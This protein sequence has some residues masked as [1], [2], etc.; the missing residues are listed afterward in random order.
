MQALAAAALVVPCLKNGEH[1]FEDSD[2]WKNTMEDHST[3]DTDRQDL[4][5]EARNKELAQATVEG[6]VY[7]VSLD[8]TRI[9]SV[10]QARTSGKTILM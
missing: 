6:R 9:K 1:G 4:V 5:R 2:E 3:A 10:E 7:V 8:S